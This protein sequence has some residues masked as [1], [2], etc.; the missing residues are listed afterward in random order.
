MKALP[1]GLL[2]L[3]LALPLASA[4]GVPPL[5]ACGP[6]TIPAE[7]VPPAAPV[8]SGERVDLV[9]QVQLAGQLAATV[10]VTAATSSP[11]WA[12]VTSPPAVPMQPGNSADFRFTVEAGPDAQQEALIAFSANGACDT[13]LGG[14]CPGGACAAGSANSQVAVPYREAQGLRFPGLD[15]LAFPVEYLIAAIV[16]VGLAT[17]IPFAMRKPRSGVVA[18]CPEPLK[19]VKP[20]LG[21]SFPIEVRNNGRE[22]A[23]THFDIGPVPEGWSAFVP[24][25]EMQLAP[26]EARSLWLMVRSPAGAHAGDAVDVELRLRDTKGASAGIVRVRAEVQGE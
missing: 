13:P 17:A 16:L 19:M 23:T 9:V 5:Q 26:R 25:P 4:Q 10:T 8:G 24:L 18:G 21:A 1:L 3:L 11:G 7:P 22:A 15:N 12:I 20:G 2:V 6:L 14:S